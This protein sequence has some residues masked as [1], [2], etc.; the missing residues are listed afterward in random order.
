MQTLTGE[1]EHE[2]LLTVAAAGKPAEQHPIRRV[3]T[4]SV[5]VEHFSSAVFFSLSPSL[6]AGRKGG[7]GLWGE[8]GGTN[9]SRDSWPHSQEALALP[10]TGPMRL[11]NL[12]DLEIPK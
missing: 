4:S 2:L 12:A 8:G 11:T 5:T 1:V 7:R 10:P 6:A 9:T 3:R